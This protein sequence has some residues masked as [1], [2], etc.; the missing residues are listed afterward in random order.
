MV[1]NKAKLGNHS[2]N[3]DLSLSKNLLPFSQSYQSY[4]AAVREQ[5][6]SGHRILEVGGGAHPSIPDRAQVEYTIVDP[7]VSELTKAPSDVVQIESSVQEL[8]DNKEYDLI[9]S[10][11]VL[12]HVP[13]PNSFHESVL[14]L[15][16]PG[17]KAIHFFACRNSVPAW[18]NRFLPEHWGEAILR[19]LQNRDLASQPKYE[20][21]YQRVGGPSKKQIK[22]FE[23]MGYEI[24]QYTGYVGHSYLKNVPLLCQLEKAY[25]WVLQAG[26]VK[27]LSTV[28]LVIL[29][30]PL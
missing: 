27:A 19:Q 15:L 24:V 28:A 26:K 10:K 23:Q 16:T 4:Y 17:G 18:V 8:D 11:M 2:R 21:Y 3:Q 6:V 13:D 14:R 5:I 1:K 25:T 9:I 12:E 7:D 22:F 20:A 30:K 29:R